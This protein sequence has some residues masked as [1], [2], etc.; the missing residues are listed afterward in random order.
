MLKFLRILFATAALVVSSASA[1]AKSAAE[2]VTDARDYALAPL[3]WDAGDWRWAGGAALSIAAAYSLDAQVRDHFVGNAAPTHADSHGVRDAT[4]LALLTAGALAVGVLGHH[5]RVTNTGLDMAEAVVLA[6]VSSYA[7]KTLTGRKRPNESLSHD[8]WGGG[9]A[10]P[11]G[12]TAAAFAAAKVFSD[13]LDRDQWAWRALGYGLAGASAYARL[14]SNVHW[15]SDV[16]AGAAL[17]IATGRFVARRDKDDQSR[18]A[19]YVAPLDHGAM[20]GFS[21]NTQ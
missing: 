18:V 11:S 15:L 8:R 21:V 2:Y 9:D 1:N 20:L 3:H 5:E 7:L 10:F 6:T 16:V 13:R 12:H 17:G 4:P 19:F 14:D